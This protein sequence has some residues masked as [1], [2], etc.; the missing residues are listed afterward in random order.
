MTRQHRAHDTTNGHGQNKK[1]LL[2]AVLG[3]SPSGTLAAKVRGLPHHGGQSQVGAR[4]PILFQDLPLGGRRLLSDH[5]HQD[6]IATNRVGNQEVGLTVETDY[7]GYLR[8]H[9]GTR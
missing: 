5:E 3:R 1:P 9:L 8:I 7:A 6:A 2:V 4:A